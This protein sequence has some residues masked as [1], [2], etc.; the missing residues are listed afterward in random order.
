MAPTPCAARL[1]WPE[2]TTFHFRQ[3]DP[4]PQNCLA[5]TARD[6]TNHPHRTPCHASSCK[7]PKPCP[8]DRP[9]AAPALHA[10]SGSPTSAGQ[11]ACP[12]CATL[13]EPYNM[14]PP[15][16]SPAGRR[17]KKTLTIHG[18]PPWLPARTEGTR[19]WRTPAQTVRCVHLCPALHDNKVLRVAH[20]SAFEST[21]HTTY[22]VL[23]RHYA[24][25][26][27]SP[28]SAIMCTGRNLIDIIRPEMG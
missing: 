4:T 26:Q 24:R 12:V 15:N 2:T 9:R 19:L 16:R 11:C 7:N 21:F 14:P 22:S 28:D 8:G 25:G 18:Q 10:R 1:R 20:G 27:H 3:D 13:P 5:P 6:D 17:V 23:I